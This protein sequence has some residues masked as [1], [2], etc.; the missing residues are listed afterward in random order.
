MNFGTW[1]NKNNESTPITIYNIE[2]KQDDKSK[3][4][5]VKKRH[6]HHHHHR[7]HHNQIQANPSIS[8]IFDCKEQ[9]MTCPH[10]KK[11][12]TTKIEKSFNCT[13]LF[14]CIL[15]T[16]FSPFIFIVPRALLLVPEQTIS[17]Q[18]LIVLAR[19]SY[20]VK[21]VLNLSLAEAGSLLQR[22]RG[23][24]DHSKRLDI[25]CLSPNAAAN[26]AIK[27]FYHSVF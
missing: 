16:I 19:K 26:P 7:S 20:N 24:W 21:W 3:I 11:R 1:Q 13:S 8:Q 27:L 6:H 18:S 9:N 17:F 22:S 12:I 2:A 14:A 10:C 5:N 25:N 23:N 15:F 4:A